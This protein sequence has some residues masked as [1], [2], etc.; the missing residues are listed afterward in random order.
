VGGVER[1]V[2]ERADALPEETRGLVLVGRERPRATAITVATVIVKI[3][4]IARSKII[5]ALGG[6]DACTHGREL[7]L[8]TTPIPF[9]TLT[10]PLR[11]LSTIYLIWS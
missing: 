2:D 11:T 4:S 8:G 6:G 10:E 3:P 7:I 1:I 5:R 9:R